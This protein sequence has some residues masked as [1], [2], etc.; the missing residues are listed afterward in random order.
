M[1]CCHVHP[2]GRFYAIAL[3]LSIPLAALLLAG[4]SG[5]LA[6]TGAAS[7]LTLADQKLTGAGRYAGRAA[8]A[9][10][11]EESKGEAFGDNERKAL[12]LEE[13]SQR[14]APVLPVKF[15]WPFGRSAAIAGPHSEISRLVNT[16][17]T[18]KNDTTKIDEPFKGPLRVYMYDLPPLSTGA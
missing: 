14:S 5:P 17:S 18:E 4:H 10:A 8:G 7:W 12:D 9:G 6:R 13:R 11:S 1:S 16:T 2:S 15:R 3:V